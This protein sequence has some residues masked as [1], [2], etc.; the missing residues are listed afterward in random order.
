MIDARFC[1]TIGTQKQHNYLCYLL[2][3]AGEP[4][5]RHWVADRLGVSVSKM[6]RLTVTVK[7]AT[8]L[9][10]EAKALS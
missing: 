4:S 3:R 8:K 5:L 2:S 10:D 7:Q 1:T 6:G 9:I